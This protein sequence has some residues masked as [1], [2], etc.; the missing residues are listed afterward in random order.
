[1]AKTV[2]EVSRSEADKLGATF[3]AMAAYF[4]RTEDSIR[5]HMSVMRKRGD[6]LPARNRVSVRSH[7]SSTTPKFWS[8]VALVGRGVRR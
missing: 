6:E 2:K 7:S 5:V 8:I 4:G 3:S 1:M